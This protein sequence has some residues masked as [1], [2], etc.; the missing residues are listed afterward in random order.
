MPTAVRYAFC[1]EPRYVLLRRIPALTYRCTIKNA[2]PK[3]SRIQNA[4][5]IALTAIQRPIHARK[6]AIAIH[7]SHMHV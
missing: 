4:A 2:Q 7:K 1:T 5:V 6:N 3:P